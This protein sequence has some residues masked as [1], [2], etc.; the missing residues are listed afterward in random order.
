MDNSG[1]FKK[2]VPFL[3][4]INLFFLGIGIIFSIGHILYD[5]SAINGANNAAP[6]FGDTTQYIPMWQ[7]HIIF[8]QILFVIQAIAFFLNFQLRGKNIQNHKLFPILLIGITILSITLG[9]FS[10]FMAIGLL[11]S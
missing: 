8:F 9:I 1:T 4:I 2:I 10:T 3:L 5:S 11:F 6:W 7:L